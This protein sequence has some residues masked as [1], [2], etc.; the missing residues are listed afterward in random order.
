MMRWLGGRPG[1]AFAV[2]V[3]AWMTVV[4]VP[5]ALAFPYRAQIGRTTVLA[6]QPIG[7][8]MV[9]VLARADRLE[10][11]S[12]LA[13][14]DA[15]RSV[16]LTDGGWRWRVLAPANGNAFGL[17]RPF[18]ATLVFNRSDIARDR[19]RNGLAVAGERTLSDTIAHETMHRDVAAHLGELRA[20]M[21]P[22]WV[23]EGYPDFVAQESSLSD[24]EATRARATGAHPP[25]LFYYDA[26]RRVAAV[27]AARGGDPQALFGR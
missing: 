13:L 3:A 15:S 4:R 22:P 12:P 2:L 23:A 11:A 20:L 8:A 16:V 9:Q 5:A 19:V 24:A 1:L 27:L 17:R 10:A 14:Q 18:S 25:A 26:R 6:E 7:T 21:L